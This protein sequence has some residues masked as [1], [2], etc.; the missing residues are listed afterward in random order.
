MLTALGKTIERKPWFVIIVILII[1][2]GF[3]TLIPS[4]EFRTDYQEFMPDDELV[5]ANSRVLDYF[6]VSQLPLFLLIEK[7]SEESVITPQSLRE[8][9]FIENEIKKFPHV[10]NTISIMTFLNAVCLVEFGNTINNCTD[11][12]IEIALND[13]LMEEQTGEIR[14]FNTDD[15]N[16]NIDY[17]RYPRISKG[18]SIDSADIKNCY[19][20]K[21]NNTITFTIEVYDLSSLQ[22]KLRPSLNKINV[23]EWYLNFE[24]LITPDERLD[25]SYR[26]AAHI[27]PIHPFWEI[28]KG[29]IGNLRELINHI[30]NRELLNSYKKEV[31]LWIKPPQQNMYFPI[32]LSS[33]NITFEKD[34]NRVNI[35]VTREELGTFGIATQ[36][37][38][39]EL[40]AKLSNFNAGIRY[41]QTSILKRPGGRVLAN[42]SFLLNKIEKIRSR[43]IIGNIVSRILQKYGNITWEDFNQLFDLMREVDLLPETL[44]LK[45]IDNAW[46]NSDI[47]PDESYSDTV[48]YIYPYLFNELQ[49][50]SFAFLSKDYEKTNSPNASLMIVQLDRLGN[51][52]EVLRIN[53]EFLKK[54]TELDK[55]FDFISVKVTGENIVS[56][57]INELTS[58][59]NQILGPLLFIIIVIILFI[60]FRRTSYVFLPMV[61]LVVSAIWL[62]GTMVLLGISFNVMAVALVP[63][64]LGIGVDYAV[65]LF[66]N[67]RAEIEK[68]KTVGE[69]I[70]ISVK[71]IGTAIFLAWLTTFIAFM[72]FLSS[73]V[74]PIRNFGVLLALGV[75]FTFITAITLLASLRYV[76][77]KKKIPKISRKLSPFS[78]KISL[79]NIMGRF[80]SIILTHQKKIIII[81]VLITLFFASGAVQ[82][83]RGF[84]LDQFV[85]ENNPAMELFDTIADYFPY[86]SE[87]QEYILIEGNIATVECLKGIIQTHKNI[88]DDTF[89]SRNTKGDTKVTSVYSII[90][91]AVKNNRSMI[92]KFNIDEKTNIPKTDED[93]QA[94]LDFL[95]EGSNFD[96][97]DFEIGEFDVEELGSSEL[98]MVLY[99]E[100]SHYIA[101]IIRYYL[102]ASFQLEGGNLQN[103]LELL[104]K[105]I[106]QDIE[107]YGDTTAI[108]TGYSLIQLSITDSLTSSQIAATGISI[109]LAAIV[110]ILAYRK[111]TLGLIAMVP[112]GITIIWILGTMYYFGYI[113]D[114][115]TV[116]V[117]SIT[118]G[119]GIDYAIHPTERFRLV[120][121]KTGDIEKAVRETISHTGAALLISALTTAIAFG[122]LVLAPIPPQ[123]RFGIILAITISYSFLTSVIF[124]PLFLV[125]WA[126]WQKKRKGYII[127]PGPPKNKIDN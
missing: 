91:N 79:K 120:A 4:I 89:I 72:S 125:R 30:I 16:E 8:M 78:V 69:A 25:I 38:S 61:T 73:S 94:L 59:A 106:N 11:E 15:P 70:K 98:R 67:Y 42:V 84:D 41:Y 13:I 12:Q 97:G 27:E 53:D 44:A 104:N 37:G 124:L 71:D 126:K 56:A 43:P 68:G 93:V 122:I 107:S 58:E 108:A 103:D 85:P 80:S 18:K 36:V 50:N 28:G 9:S 63:L 20:S 76:L 101:T 62:L 92:N 115:M 55:E 7:Q 14:L 82:L 26:I 109:F 39:F 88:E 19:I 34:S 5:L 32:P 102:D 66:H 45:D 29:F 24:N 113:L 6:G 111:F 118:I 51:Y 99:K 57:Q 33:G 46:I 3:A 112:V 83:R 22:S 87:Y 77:D 35:V 21:D 116:T 86:A 47:A 48:F 90:Q 52:D 40:P 95:Y 117:T 17:K 31:Y 49:L 64:I 75:T 114:V 127:S 96:M 105:E 60:F 121:D 123:Q 23:M 74:P 10:N 2:A 1:T 119:I 54:I 65:H 81:M 110:L 100:N